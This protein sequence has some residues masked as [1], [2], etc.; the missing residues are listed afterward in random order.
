MDPQ[1]LL[2]IRHL[3]LVRGGRVVLAGFS[4]DL[5]PA[6]RGLVLGANGSG[7]SSLALAVAGLLR[8][9]GGAIRRPDRVGLAP[10]EPRFP[11]DLPLARMLA[12]LAA[13][14]GSRPAEARRL[15]GEALER[16]GLEPDAR[17]RVGELSRGWRQRL[18]LA[19]AWLGRPPLVI[20]DEPQTALD[21]DGMKL[22]RR[23]L[24]EEN[25]PAALILAPPA[26]GCDGLAPVLARIGLPTREERTR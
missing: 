1:P 5:A 15:A 18:N 26:T 2:T 6:E 12:E 3:R 20:L 25:G 11:A 23:N 9:A 17:R 16:F 7:K 22:L 14:G 4:L 8:P 13:L 19:R 10:Q 21:P 24:A